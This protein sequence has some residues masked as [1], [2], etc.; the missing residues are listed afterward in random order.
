MKAPESRLWLVSLAHKVHDR[1]PKA[2]TELTRGRQMRSLIIW[3]IK[4]NTGISKLTCT[5]YLRKRLFSKCKLSINIQYNGGGLQLSCH[6]NSMVLGRQPPCSLKMTG[7]PNVGWCQDTF[8]HIMQNEMKATNSFT[9]NR[10]G[11]ACGPVQKKE[12]KKTKLGGAAT[13]DN[14]PSDP[15]TTHPSEVFCS[16]CWAH[17]CLLQQR[18]AAHTNVAVTK[19]SIY[20]HSHERQ[21][22]KY[23]R[24]VQGYHSSYGTLQ[25][26]DYIQWWWVFSEVVSLVYEARKPF[27]AGIGLSYNIYWTWAALG[28]KEA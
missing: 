2:A 25:S 16:A 5:L 7:I 12:K 10:R 24:N 3:Q 1:G 23:C 28:A 6:Q 26:L 4:K 18:H 20:P 19:W 13:Y 22:C 9:T 14:T 15:M 17:R 27:A 21:Q 8:V 11:R